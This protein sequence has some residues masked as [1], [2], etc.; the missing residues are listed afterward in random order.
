MTPAPMPRIA[1][2]GRGHARKGDSSLNCP[3]GPQGRSGLVQAP[4]RRPVALDLFCG[5]GGASAG[6][7][8]AGFDVIGID[9]QPQPHYVHPGR[10]IQG[11]AL[12]PPVDLARFDFIWASPPCQAFSAATNMRGAMA[13]THP[14]LIPPI[15]MIL[16]ASGV[17][18]A[19]EN[20]PRAP[21]RPDVILDGDMFGLGTYRKRVFEIGGFFVLTPPPSKPFG[22]FSRP[23]AVTCA[24]RTG[25]FKEPRTGRVVHRG[26]PAEWRAALRIDWPMP[27][28]A[29]AQCVPPAY[30]EFIGHQALAQICGEFRRLRHQ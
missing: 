7:A 15:R 10:F 19:I 5:A 23:G 24:G 28:R 11:D 27:A 14:N 26:T 9:I 1:A 20:V 18:Y 21:L 3:A 13:K 6:L 16:E 12:S 17:P 25:T 30:A 2:T 8:L 22:P 4:A 29:M